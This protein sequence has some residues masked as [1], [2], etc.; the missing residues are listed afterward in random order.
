MTTYTITLTDKEE[1]SLKRLLAWD[2]ED[3]ST[4]D[5]DTLLRKRIYT[6]LLESERQVQL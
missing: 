6:K 4:L 1:T 5:P 2:L 3:K